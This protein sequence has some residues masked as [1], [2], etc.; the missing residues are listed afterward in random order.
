MC[1]GE[2]HIN[3]LPAI[4]FTSLVLLTKSAHGIDCFKCVSMN[5]ANKACDDPFHNN[6]STAILESPC[7]GGRKGRDGLFPATS[8]I[9]IAG[10]YDDTRE[11]ITV[12][13]CALDSGTL[14]TDTEIIRMSHCGRFFY[15]DRYVH[16]CL[17]SCNDADACN[18]SSRLAAVDPYRVGFC[19]AT[20]YLLLYYHRQQALSSLLYLGYES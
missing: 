17:Q 8:C 12:R 9:K 3:Y 7:M 4:L 13:G 20:L 1:I 2:Q 6:Y 14:T 5:G 19:L 11:T 18:H 16:G 15:D 10:Y